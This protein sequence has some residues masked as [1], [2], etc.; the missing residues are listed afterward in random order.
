[1]HRR[2]AV[3]RASANFLHRPARSLRRPIS[4]L[5]TFGAVAGVQLQTS[6]SIKPRERDLGDLRLFVLVRFFTRPTNR[7]RHA[8]CVSNDESKP[9]RPLQL[10]IYD[11][12]LCSQPS[13]GRANS[14]G[15][16][17]ILTLGQPEITMETHVD[18]LPVAKS[19]F[20]IQPR[21]LP[22]VGSLVLVIGIGYLDY[23]T[24]YEESLLL[25]YLIPIVLVI[26]FG[27]IWLGL[28][29]SVLSVLASI[30]SD[31][32]AG[33]PAIQPWNMGMAL[34]AY[35]IFTLLFSKLRTLLYKLDERVKERTAALQHEMAERERLDQEIAE[36]ADRER[37]RLGQNLHDSLGQH[38]TGTALA[39]E[40]LREKL[41]TRAAA[42][43][44]DADKVVRYLE[45]GIDLTRNLARG[46]F[47]PELDADGLSVA[48]QGLA[49]NITER[50]GVQCN[51]SGNEA[52]TVRDATTATQ[53]YHIAQEA[54]MNAVKH[55]NASKIDILLANSDG[56]F[57]LTV[58]DNGDGFPDKLAQ[59]PGLGLRL[60]AH[61]AT[62][63]G[64]K[65]VIDRNRNGGTVVTCKL[66][67]PGPNSN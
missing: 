14:D 47:S 67:V 56:K 26:W 3:S 57:D 48:L 19:R 63:I 55:A 45:E 29:L 43:V 1:L 30:I 66:N 44:P 52:V 65:F 10:Q 22:V 38:L 42:E 12:L 32:A 9:V 49:A 5:S 40:V 28:L 23:V 59:P 13:V 7:P 21:W 16:G 4:L 35:V 33:I 2:T 60:M 50:F 54:A 17:S 41:A 51:F 25:F 46:F 61:G 64:G 20:S 11:H 15:T 34:L 58:T 36:V 53:L 8:A 27:N 6:R 18:Q 31:V 37:R 62:L 39:A 24:G